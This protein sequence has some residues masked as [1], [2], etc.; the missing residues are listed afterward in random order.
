MAIQEAAAA[1]AAA[2]AA[3]SAEKASSWGP[4]EPLHALLGPIFDTLKPLLSGNAALLIIGALLFMYFFRGPSPSPML[5]DDVGCPSWT[6]PQRLA[7]YE[8]MWRREESELWNWLEDRVGMDGMSFPTIH[9]SMDS[10]STRN[11]IRRKLQGEREVAARLNEDKMSDR[12]M[13]HAIRTTRERLDLLEDVLSKRSS[14]PKVQGEKVNDDTVPG[15][16]L[17]SD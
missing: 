8:E 16:F 1:S 9:R 10:Q 7:A 5:S 11:Q 3:A 15:E 12:E 14:E 2:A 13:V 4:L 6:A 17:K